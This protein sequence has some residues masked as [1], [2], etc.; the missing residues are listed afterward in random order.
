MAGLPLSLAISLWLVGAVWV[1]AL[2]TYFFDM[3]SDI[4][5]FVLFIGSATGLVELRMRNRGK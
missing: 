1:V 4:V 3:S 5:W 2:G